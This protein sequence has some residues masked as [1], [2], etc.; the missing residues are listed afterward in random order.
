MPHLCPE[1]LPRPPEA[2]LPA[3][4]AQVSKIMHRE[5]V[6]VALGAQVGD[7]ITYRGS[8]EGSLIY[9]VFTKKCQKWTERGVPPVFDRKFECIT[10]WVSFRARGALEG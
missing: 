4:V 2:L 5:G 8:P 9:T 6:G 7:V 3:T 10:Y 1:P